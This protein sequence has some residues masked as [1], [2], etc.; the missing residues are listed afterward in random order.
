[1]SILDQ[2]ERIRQALADRAD[3][4]PGQLDIDDE[5]ALRDMLARA[6][7][8]A[9]RLTALAAER[10]TLVTAELADRHDIPRGRVVIADAGPKE[11]LAPPAVRGTLQVDPRLTQRRAP[12]PVWGVT[13]WGATTWGATTWGAVRR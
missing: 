3:G 4:R 6:P 11:S 12:A 5:A 1:M 8:D 7:V 10:V 13:P 9:D 2:R